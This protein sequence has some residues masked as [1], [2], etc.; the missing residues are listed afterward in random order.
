MTEREQMLQCL[1]CDCHV[2]LSNMARENRP[3]SLWQ[4]F[5]TPRW[6]ISH[7]P[8][9]ADARHLLPRIEAEIFPSKRV[10]P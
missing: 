5:T 1:L 9:R 7:E 2:V 8:L 10:K 4:V 3:R 6:P